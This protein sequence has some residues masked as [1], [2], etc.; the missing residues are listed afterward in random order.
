MHALSTIGSD[1]VLC[2]LLDAHNL[3]AALHERRVKGGAKSDPLYEYEYA[4]AYEYECV[5]CV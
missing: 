5:V 2:S 4:Y 1:V 3:G